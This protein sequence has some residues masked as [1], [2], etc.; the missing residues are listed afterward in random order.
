MGL[1][2]AESGLFP[3]KQEGMGVSSKSHSWGR[4]VGSD[5][6]NTKGLTS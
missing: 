1:R 2:K 3:C 4:A 6:Q 5:S